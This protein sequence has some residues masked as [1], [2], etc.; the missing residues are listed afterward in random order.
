ML[1]QGEIELKVLHCIANLAPRYGGP[2][3]ACLG[4]ARALAA[5]GHQVSL[6]TTNQDGNETLSVPLDEPVVTDGVEVRYF[7]IQPPRALATSLPLARA[8]FRDVSN[9]DLVHVHSLYLFHDWAASAAC[10]RHRVPYLIRPHGS[11]DPYLVRRHRLRKAVVNRLFQ[12]R[13]LRRAAAIH[14]TAEEEGRLARPH[15]FGRPEVIVP[16]GLD[17]DAFRTL[18]PPGS[19]RARHPEL[20]Q[21]PLLLFLGRINF[22][23]GLKLLLEAFPRI[24]DTLPGCRLVLAGPDNEGYGQGLR[25]DIAARGLTD[26]VHFTGMLDGEE[27]LALLRD[28]DL[29]VLPSYTENF[30]IAVIEAMA[31]GLPVVL[32]DRVNIHREV[33]A[34]G[35]GL[36]TPCEAGPLADACARILAAP[37]LARDMGRAGRAL[38]ERDYRWSSVGA[39]LEAAY[40]TLLDRTPAA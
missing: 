38:V 17:P 21:A 34:A 37:T 33:R 27:K 8:L 36:V 11:L 40:Q 39:R 5:R 2:P 30:G 31:C 6:Y 29:F 20:A 25:K 35:A 10:R 26:S 19:F 13:A 1:C 24:R 23:K 15:V 9:F 32:S 22:K 4:M 14:F 18:P 12:D 28:A 3:R 7:P 16:I